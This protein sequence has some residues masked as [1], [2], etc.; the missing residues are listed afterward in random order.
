V[1]RYSVPLEGEFPGQLSEFFGASFQARIFPLDIEPLVLI[2][3]YLMLGEIPGDLLSPFG[4]T[5]NVPFSF[6]FS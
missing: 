2:H 4:H 5:A 3:R 6:A 1:V